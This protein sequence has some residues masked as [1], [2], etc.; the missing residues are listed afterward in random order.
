MAI[1]SL[2]DVVRPSSGLSAF[3]SGGGG[4]GGVSGVSVVD[5]GVNAA[6]TSQIVVTGQSGITLSSHV[7]AW[8]MADSTA[9]NDS[10]SHMLGS[11]LIDVVVGSL[12]NGVGFTLTAICD[13][14]AIGKFNVHWSY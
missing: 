12:V 3:L 11:R 9:E 7:R 10:V 2:S 14:R 5:F 4:G 6:E 8:I 13:S 1:E